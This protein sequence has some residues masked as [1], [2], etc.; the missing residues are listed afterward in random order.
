M[1]KGMILSINESDDFFKIR[2]HRMPSSFLISKSF[3]RIK[4]T[5]K[6]AEKELASNV[7][8][9]QKTFFRV[10]PETPTAKGGFLLE[11]EAFSFNAG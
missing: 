7:F 1:F 8:W 6:C 9:G 5:R 2:V 10:C 11:Q 4:V 3:T